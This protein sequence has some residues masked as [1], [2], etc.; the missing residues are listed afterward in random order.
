M[1]LKLFFSLW[2]WPMSQRSGCDGR[3]SGD[4]QKV[5]VADEGVRP[6]GPAIQPSFKAPRESILFKADT[7]TD[8]A[9]KDREEERGRRRGEEKEIGEV[10]GGW[11]RQRA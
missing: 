3:L 11:Q 4:K 8:V 7:Q 10:K 5:S 9:G 2:Q 6:A 1:A